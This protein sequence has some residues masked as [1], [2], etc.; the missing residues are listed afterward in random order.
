MALS[1]ASP[2]A[3]GLAAPAMVR[4]AVQTRHVMMSAA[5]GMEG[6]SHETGMKTWDPLGLAD[7]GSPATLAFFRHA[8][9]KHC[10]V[11]MAAFVG[12]LVAV[13]GVHFPGLCSF[14][15][16]VSFEDI[17]KLTPLEQWAAVPALGKAQ[18]LLAIGIIEH[19]SEWKIKPHYMAAGGKPGD[20]KGLKSFWDPAGLTSKMSAAK[21]ERQRLSELKNGRAA[22]IGII[23]V[24]IAH[25]V[26]GSIP[27]PINF[28]AG[29]SLILPF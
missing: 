11:A 10:R 12:W 9:L 24:L 27:L 4:P 8:E 29:P 1:L 25:N 17:S 23:S 28:P 26:P 6:I 7:L 15:E 20:L 19:N 5:D 13:S 3:C 2:L 21:L 16:G 22:M 14:S 18:I